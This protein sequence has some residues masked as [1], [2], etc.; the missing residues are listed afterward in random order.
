[1]SVEPIVRRLSAYVALTDEDARLVEEL[2]R[3]R[4]RRVGPRED[5]LREGERPHALYVVLDGWAARYKSLEDGRRQVLSF[6]LPGDLC[7][8]HV[9]LMPRADHSLGAITSVTVAEIPG[10]RV[11]AIAA[12]SPRLSTALAWSDLCAQTL[13]REWTVNLGQRSALERMAH[14][15]CELFHR[16]R[17]V[18]LTHGLSYE[19]P[20]TQAML[21]DATGISA[22]HVNRT[23]QE[24]RAAELITLRGRHMTIHDLEALEAAGLFSPAYLHLEQAAHAASTAPDG[25][26]P[27]LV[28]RTIATDG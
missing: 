7:E 19:L 13:Q 24:L 5:V 22:V 11:A 23:L 16:L 25:G 28:L 1:M 4:I 21:A 18:G 20:A 10:A 12:A 26:T 9:L 27:V 6:V 8:Q 2:C 3:E 14:L 15:I 17:A